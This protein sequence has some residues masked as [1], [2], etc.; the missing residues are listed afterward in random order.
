MFIYACMMC[1]KLV[2]GMH[3]VQGR[4]GEGMP[5]ITLGLRLGLLRHESTPPGPAF[6]DPVRMCP[7]SF[8]WP[9]TLVGQF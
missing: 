6:I 9:D 1:V 2:K 7:S 5:R 8:L 3:H 4:V